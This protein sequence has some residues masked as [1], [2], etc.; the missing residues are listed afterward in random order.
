MEFRDRGSLA[1]RA[2]PVVKQAQDHVSK[3][4]FNQQILRVGDAAGEFCILLLI[5]KYEECLVTL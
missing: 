5:Q 2:Q 3:P 4:I 1:R